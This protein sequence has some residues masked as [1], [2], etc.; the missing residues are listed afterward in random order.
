MNLRK[1]ASLKIAPIK[2]SLLLVMPFPCCFAGSLQFSLLPVKY[3]KLFRSNFPNVFQFLKENIKETLLCGLFSL[4]SC[5]ATLG[6]CK[7]RA[8]S[9]K[10]KAEILVRNSHTSVAFD[11]TYPFFTCEKAAIAIWIGRVTFFACKKHRP[12][13]F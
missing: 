7:M 12:M 1:R 4:N 13:I 3:T 6:R 2:S 10:Q 5:E 8:A 9:A 11:W